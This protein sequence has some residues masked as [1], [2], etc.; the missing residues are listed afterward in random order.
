MPKVNWSVRD[1]VAIVTIDNP[2]VNAVGPGIPEEAAECIAQAE[3]DDSVRAVVM[4]GAGR[5]FIAG[6]DFT[7]FFD[8]DGLPR[9]HLLLERMENCTKPLVVAIHGMALGG[10]LE[11][12][13]GGHYRVASPDAQVGQP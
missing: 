3:R 8:P 13:M 5:T 4:I 11:I 6:A 9:I 7:R 10:G 2:P 12:A 1:G